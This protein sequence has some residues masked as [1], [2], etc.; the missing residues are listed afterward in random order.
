M[1]ITSIFPLISSNCFCVPAFAAI[2][3]SVLFLETVAVFSCDFNT[4]IWDRTPLDFEDIT[5]FDAIN[6]S[7]FSANWIVS[8]YPTTASFLRACPS[9]TLNFNN[10]PLLSAE[11]VVSVASKFPYPS[12]SSELELQELKIIEKMA[13]YSI[14]NIDFICLFFTYF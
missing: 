2:K 8:I 14:V 11:I 1:F 5:F 13:V 7:F 3:F 9:S 10:L 4:L 6:C 12:A